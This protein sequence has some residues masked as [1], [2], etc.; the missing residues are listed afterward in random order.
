[1]ETKKKAAKFD[2]LVHLR[3]HFTLSISVNNR[4]REKKATTAP[5]T[6]VIV[7]D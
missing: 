6:H 4:N 2:G 5:D 1:M 7:T 3:S